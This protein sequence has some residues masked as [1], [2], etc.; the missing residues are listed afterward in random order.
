M[1]RLFLFAAIMLSVQVSAQSQADALE[2]LKKYAV[3]DTI[4]ISV[5]DILNLT[6]YWLSINREMN[7]QDERN[8]R[9]R[10]ESMRRAV[11]SIVSENMIHESSEH[12]MRN[13]IDKMFNYPYSVGT[14]G[15]HYSPIDFIPECGD[16]GWKYDMRYFPMEKYYPEWLKHPMYRR[17]VEE[18]GYA[19]IDSLACYLEYLTS[20][21]IYGYTT[22][23]HYNNEDAIDDIII[24]DLTDNKLRIAVQYDYSHLICHSEEGIKKVKYGDM[25][26]GFRIH[27][28]YSLDSF[29]PY[30]IQNFEMGEL[31]Q[32]KIITEDNDAINKINAILEVLY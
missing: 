8:V 9:G 21:T 10:R 17:N 30:V 18:N 13:I 19:L 23:I 14:D 27:K 24:Y 16:C 11:D 29:E 6:D 15:R 28:T 7:Y 4:K 1:K 20:D 25:P 31:N 26:R 2:V 32:V 22:V 3:N 5:Q 12:L